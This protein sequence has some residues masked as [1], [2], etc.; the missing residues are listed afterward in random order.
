MKEYTSLTSSPKY[1]LC[2]ADTNRL[3]LTGKKRSYNWTGNYLI[4]TDHENLTTESEGYIGKVRSN[5]FGTKFEIFDSGQ[6]PARN[7]QTTQPREQLGK[8]NYVCK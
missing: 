1:E 2:V 5:F 6:N 4:T 8:I 3:L 7:A